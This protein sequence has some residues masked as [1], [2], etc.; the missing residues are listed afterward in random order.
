V[1]LDDSNILAELTATTRVGFHQYTFPKSVDAH[2]I[3]DLM[4]AFTITMTK[5]SGLM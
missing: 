4:S 2:I 1:K 3:L 5:M